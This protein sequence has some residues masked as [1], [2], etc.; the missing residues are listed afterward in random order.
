MLAARFLCI[1]ILVAGFLGTLITGCASTSGIEA[2]GKVVAAD[3][4][5]S[6]DKSIVIN[7]RAL[8]SDLEITDIRSAFIGDLLKVQISIR[9][10]NRDTF[11]IQYK[12]EWLDA[13]GFEINTNQAW[14]PFIVYGKETKTIQGV[15]PDQRAQEFKIKIRD[16]D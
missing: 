13:Q 5:H 6:L 16:P 14:K 4:G 7:N 9:S 2:S 3:S 10:A 1:V 8:A 11:P 12:F 15:A